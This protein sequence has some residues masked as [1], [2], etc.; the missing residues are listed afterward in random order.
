MG[1][2][3]R[4]HYREANPDDREIHPIDDEVDRR[5]DHAR[6]RKRI[7][8][9]QGRVMA[10]L[11]EQRHLYLR[12][13]E[14]V[15]ERHGE[16]EEAM[17]DVGF[18]HG[19]VQGRADALSAALGRQGARGRAL[20]ARIAR[21]AATAGPTPRALAALLEVA[22]GVAVGRRKPPTVRA[23]RRRRPS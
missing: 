19:L 18:E 20:A 22:W 7:I 3:R 21:L 8:A 5:L 11:G 23:R 2:R 13:E 15:G 14:L 10:A 17:F 1:G 16:R 6:L 4:N 9:A 12:L